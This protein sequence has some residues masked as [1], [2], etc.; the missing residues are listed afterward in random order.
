MTAEAERRIASY[1]DTRFLRSYTRSKL[2]SDPVYRA[3]LERL[4]DSAVPLYDIGCGVGLLEAYLRENGIEIAIT[5]IDH[6]ERK[7]AKARA[8]ATRYRDLQFGLGDARDDVP[9]RTNVVMVDV[10]HYFTA[11]DQQ[12]ILGNVAA[13]GGDLVM[14]RDA[15]RDRTLRYRATAAQERFA[16]A[17][18]WLRAE[19]L[20]FPSA[21]EISRPFGERGY[22]VEVEPMW[23]RT[24]FNNYL[25]VFRRSSGGTTNR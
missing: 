15:V 21:D 12:R 5:G 19:R 23:G 8:I 11:A 13:A 14:I 9:P 10:L 17:V 6:D 7:I 22:R 2:R 3:I 25:F 16:R 18:R 24:P 1:F 20:N 4:R